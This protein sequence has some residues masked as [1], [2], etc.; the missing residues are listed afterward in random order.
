MSTLAVSERSD[1]LFGTGGNDFLFGVG[2]SLGS[3]D[4]T[5]QCMW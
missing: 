4:L 2:W 1:L 3:L 5:I